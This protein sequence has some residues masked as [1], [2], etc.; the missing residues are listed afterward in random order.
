[1]L[2]Q[3]MQGFPVT[4]FC[5]AGTQGTAS[6][7]PGLPR[8]HHH[9]ILNRQEQVH[10]ADIWICEILFPQQLLLKLYFNFGRG[11]VDFNVRLWAGVC[12]RM[13][14]TPGGAD[15]AGNVGDEEL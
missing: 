1:M 15:A 13:S 2:C 12:V 6:Q 7:Q 10:K 14:G 4:G 9:L 8:S 5:H 3:E 11:L